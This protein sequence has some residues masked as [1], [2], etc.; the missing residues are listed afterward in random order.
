MTNSNT[1]APTSATMFQGELTVIALLTSLTV[2][3]P[4][5]DGLVCCCCLVV[6]IIDVICSIFDTKNSVIVIVQL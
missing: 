3:N 2:V 6:V 5:N 1:A 4:R